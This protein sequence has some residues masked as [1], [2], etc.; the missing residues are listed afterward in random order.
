MTMYLFANW[1]MNP[2]SVKEAEKLATETQ[3][4]LSGKR[5]EVVVCPPFLYLKTVK[6]KTDFSLG[7]QNC[8]WEQRGSYTGEVSPEMLKSI[9]CQ[10]AIIGHSERR[11]YFKEGEKEIKKKVNACLLAGITPVL[12]VGETKKERQAK[13]TKKVLKNQLSFLSQKKALIAYEPR[14]AIGSGKTPPQKELKEALSFIKN[15]FKN[16]VLYGGSV[17]G[18]NADLF[19]KAGFDGVLVGGASL[20]PKEFARVTKK[21]ES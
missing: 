10:Y 14:W 16:S 9:G 18:Q 21:L 7:A 6:E 12:C 20:K 8:F 5:L 1:K 17:D 15:N 13:K 19:K 11:K 3:K 2:Q 4:L